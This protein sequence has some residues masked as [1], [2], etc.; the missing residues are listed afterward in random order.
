MNNNA[1]LSTMLEEIEKQGISDQKVLHAMKQ[2]DRIHFIPDDLKMLA[3]LNEPIPIDCGQTISQ[4]YI[5]A[6]MLEFLN[7]LPHERV[8]EIGTGSGYN[9]AILSQLA[10]IVYTVELNNIL[11]NE[12]SER[13]SKLGLDNVFVSQGDGLQG[14]KIKSPF[15]VII[16]TAAIESVPTS[17]FEQLA[18][19]GRLIAPVGEDHNQHL[20][21]W[22]KN[23]NE[24]TREL[25]I[26]VRFV[27]MLN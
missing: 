2:T 25:L 12:A 23:K 6:Y 20:Y 13:L 17:L 10:K 18:D 11:A 5:V 22:R 1:M 27:K 15:D 26:P 3:Y 21:L 8:L 16:L 9:A 4:P 7:I 14:L 24:L 19:G